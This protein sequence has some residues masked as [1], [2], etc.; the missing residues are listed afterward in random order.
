MQF[1]WQTG[2]K[3]AAV[4]AALL[5]AHS[6]TAQLAKGEKD[7][8]AI[9]PL[10]VKASVTQVANAQQQTL[11]LNR[12]KD[13]V[14][15]QFHSALAATRV[16]DL[17]ERQRAEELK[18]EQ[19][20]AQVEVNP[21][22]K[23][24]A[25]AMKMAG[26][27]FLF[28]PELDGFQDRLDSKEMAMT[29]ERD[30]RQI[31]FASMTVR[32]VDATTGKYLPDVPSEQV[33]VGRELINT[34]A[35]DIAVSREQM[36]ADAAKQLA[37]NLTIR[38]VSILR[39]AKVLAVTGRQIMINRGVDVG[40]EPGAMVE[41]YATA[42]VK[43]EDTGEIFRNE[44][45][46]GRGQIQR[47][48]P[49]QSFAAVAG[50]DT[51]I[52]KG[53][54]VKII[55][56]AQPGA[57]ASAAP[58]AAPVAPAP[59]MQAPA[60]APAPAPAPSGSEKPFSWDNNTA[61]LPDDPAAVQ[62]VKFTH[63]KLQKTIT[64]LGVNQGL[65]DNLLKVNVHLAARKQLQ[66][67]YKFVFYTAAGMEVEPGKAAWKPLFFAGNQNITVQ[68]IAPNGSVRSFQLFIEPAD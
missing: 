42:D 22:D 4:S 33:T 21:N 16:F 53:C 64:V 26:A 47:A 38:L 63:Q 11:A 51:G 48:D 13:S 39:P 62:N 34:G 10:K 49:R 54:I 20:F 60:A 8:I 52:A 50:E 24:A 19:A 61:P 30:A 25:Q 15:A 36:Y 35:A 5:L 59:Q 17:V 27:K 29:G 44:V 67:R 56:F 43:D 58:M 14:E 23:N 6:A 40:F 37:R 1:H 41:F 45:P 9:S 18:L 3:I 66:A 28:F 55:G 32:V 68:G 12:L 46:V 2:L 7:T 31:V 57:D 65:V